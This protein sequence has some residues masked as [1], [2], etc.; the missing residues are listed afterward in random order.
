M[1]LAFARLLAWRGGFEAL[2]DIL[3]AMLDESKA[4][5]S[6]AQK[7]LSAWNTDYL[8]SPWA[9]EFSREWLPKVRELIQHHREKETGWSWHELERLI[10][11]IERRS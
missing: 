5:R 8:V 4:V 10:S 2:S 7:Y 1:L 11:D 9:L 3:Q 6:T